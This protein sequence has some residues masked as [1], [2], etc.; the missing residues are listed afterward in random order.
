MSFNINPMCQS[1][2][3]KLFFSTSCQRLMPLTVMLCM[4]LCS[5]TLHARNVDDRELIRRVFDFKKTHQTLQ[6]DTVG[7]AYIKFVIITARRNP[8]LMCVPTMY[9]VSRGNRSYIGESYNSIKYTGGDINDIEAIVETGTIPYKRE[10]MPTMVDFVTP[11]IYDVT[12]Y[13]DH[14]ISPLHYKNRLYYRY[15]VMHRSDSTARIF[16]SPKIDNTQLVK[17]WADVMSATGRV[18]KMEIS[19]HYDMS[20]YKID[21][22]MFSEPEYSFCPRRCRS[23]VTFSF[24]GNVIYS[25][26]NAEYSVGTPSVTNIKGADERRMM[27]ELRPMN[28][29]DL[30]SDVYLEHDTIAARVDTTRSERHKKWHRVLWDN[31]GDKILSR[32]KVK[33]GTE[34]RGSF[35]LSPVLNPLYLGYSGRKGVTY[36]FNLRF[37]YVFSP[38][39]DLSLNMKGGYSFKQHQFYFRVPLYFNYNKKHNG[40][41]KLEIGNGNRIVSSE[42]LDA[43]GNRDS[44]KD[45]ANDMMHFRDFNVSLVNHYDFNDK[46]GFEAGLILH[47]RSAVSRKGFD[48]TGRPDEYY[49]FAPL[50]ELQYR[51]L[52]YRG[53]ILTVDY[54]RNIKGVGKTNTGYERIEGDLSYK[55]NFHKL[56]S[57]SLRCGAGMYTARS[58]NAYFLD[59]INFREENIVGGWND[60][61]ACE[62]Q[63]LSSA[64]YNA[65]KYYFRINNVYESPILAM[66]RVPFV[67][68]YIENE[69]IYTNILFVQNLHMYVENG[70]GFT[71]R[72]LSMGMFVATEN[73]RFHG[74]GCRF[75][76]ELF[77]KW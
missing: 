8:T 77:G 14:T 20:K 18:T 51:P 9:A 33:F 56:R 4:L 50:L 68:R 57:L 40:Y 34:N 49:S 48:I 70:Y 32:H 19:G 62:F 63:L 16:F 41:V 76:F 12:I 13:D 38:K 24:L 71:T 15:T 45:I 23:N 28:L 25:Q 27:D 43:V 21:I 67:G 72:A 22:D 66:S 1:T 11:R 52:G 2:S 37:S 47:R 30:E 5:L 73:G 17:G 65:S 29:T 7:S 69:R 75:G 44:I 35:H 6:K 58:K 10:I 59:F 60:D 36:K 3:H 61:W 54:E 55:Y 53:P 74:F 31:I 42:I 64:Y 46:I 26:H 39:Y